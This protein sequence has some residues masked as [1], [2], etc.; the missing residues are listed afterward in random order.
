[1]IDSQDFLD[2][3]YHRQLI[4]DK[5]Y[6]KITIPSKLEEISKKWKILKAHDN[7]AFA[8]GAILQSFL[9]F[10]DQDPI[11]G[12][13]IEEFFDK[14]MSKLEDE[15]NHIFNDKK[16]FKNEPIQNLIQIIL[17]TNNINLDLELNEQSK[18]YDNTTK[19]TSE[20]N[21]FNIV[22]NIEELLNSK[23]LDITKTVTNSILLVILTGLRFISIIKS[24]ENSIKWAKR[25]EKQDL[26]VLK[27]TDF[28]LNQITKNKNLK[29]FT[30]EFIQKFV[31]TQAKLIN[32][33][34]LRSNNAN[35][36]PW[37]HEIDSNYFRDRKY[38]TEHRNIRFSIAI[39]LLHDLDIINKTDDSITCTKQSQKIIERVLQ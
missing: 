38:K 4:I 34:K 1:M 6:R 17:K 29:E 32:K 20:I 5:E 25:L 30:Q 28:V 33:E 23:N 14:C 7:Y 37:F 13:T 18:Q 12:K 39:S 27:Y 16:I 22:R 26:G 10:L 8:S 35:P 31:I 36:K 9:G 3:I 15:V 24:D 2:A 21:E 11:K 19:I